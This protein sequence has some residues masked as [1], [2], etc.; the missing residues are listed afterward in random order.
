M[1]IMADLSD[2]IDIATARL[3]V[4][5]QPPNEHV[6]CTIRIHSNGT[7]VMEPDFNHGKMAYMM[8]TGNLNNEVYQYYLE[9]ASAT[10]NMH[11]LIKER[12]LFNEICSRQQTNL[13]Q[14]VGN[15]FDTVNLE[16]KYIEI[17]SL[18]FYLSHHQLFSN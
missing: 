17:I 14:I 13:T 11:D 4:L 1:Y 16:I 6:L 7:I 15:E 3:V 2:K 5:P 18:M 12:K 8:E 9:H 10:M